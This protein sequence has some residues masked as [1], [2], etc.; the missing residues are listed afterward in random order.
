MKGRI[1]E[2]KAVEQGQLERREALDWMTER[3]A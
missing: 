2:R 3:V 1:R